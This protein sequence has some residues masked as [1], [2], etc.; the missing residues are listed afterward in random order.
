MTDV[1]PVKK[2]EPEKSVPVEVVPIKE[3]PPI[4]EVPEKPY[5]V[6][7]KEDIPLG[8]GG[9]EEKYVGRDVSPEYDIKPVKFVSVAKSYLMFMDATKMI[10]FQNRSFITN[11]P[12]RINYLRKHKDN[13]R[14]YWEGDFPTWLEEK[15]EAD[16]KLLTRDPD[17]YEA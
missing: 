7:G 6:K 9:M 8:V 17:L 14:A 4:P 5:L 12:N 1:A 16:K 15:L 10:V 13:G 11:N 2:V 3:V